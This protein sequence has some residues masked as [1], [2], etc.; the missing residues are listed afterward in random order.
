MGMTID[1]W[2][3]LHFETLNQYLMLNQRYSAVHGA[4]LQRHC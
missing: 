3:N 2:V 1:M 4:D